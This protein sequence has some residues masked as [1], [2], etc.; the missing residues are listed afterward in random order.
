MFPLKDGFIRVAAGTPHIR[1]SDCEH[2]ADQ[3]IRLMKEARAAKAKIL[4][5][6]ELCLTG[7]TAGDLFAL[8]TLQNAAL[9]ALERVVKA[10]R[11][12]DLLCAVGLP[13]AVN[14][15][16]YDCAA[17]LQSGS[18]LAIVPKRRLPTH[19]PFE[20]TR[21]FAPGSA[22][23]R[24]IMLFDTQVPFGGNILLNCP[25]MPGLCVGVEISADLWAPAPPSIDHAK[26]GAVIILCP[27]AT[28]ETVGRAAYRK[29]LLASHSARLLCGYVYADAGN[30][31][32]T[33]DLVFAGHNLIAE[34][35][36]ILAASKRFECALVTA[37]LDVSYLVSDRLRLNCFG[38]QTGSHTIVPFHL[39]PEHLNLDRFIEPTPF[40]PFDEKTRA[41]RCEEILDIQTHGLMT[42]MLHINCTTAVIGV[43]G[44]LDSTL[45]LLVAARAFERM[46]LDAKGILAVTMPCFGTTRRT[47]DNALKLTGCVG[48]KLVEIDITDS[49]RQHF[50]DIGQDENSHDTTY[51]NCQARERTQVLMDLANQCGGLVIGTGDMSELALGWTTYNGDHMS[52]YAVNSGVPKTMV[53][54]LIAYTAEQ[55]REEGMREVLLDILKTPVSPELLPAKDGTISQVTEELVGPYELHDFFLYH[56]VR[57]MEEP[58]KI[59][60]L[61]CIAFEGTYPEQTIEKWLEVFLKRFFSQQYKR[62]C[63]PD[64]PRIGSVS[65]SPRGGWA[66]PSDVSGKAWH[67]VFSE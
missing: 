1:V 11:G 40:V 65:L 47:Y 43:S 39:K 42:R 18:I 6:P 27:A 14:G 62:S 54:H 63:L 34:N 67:R 56:L 46:G 35:G 15:R 41:R 20:E 23:V 26:E 13:L 55:A 28:V 12:M 21:Y 4:V 2:N 36:T 52:M 60:R 59:L 50:K 38:E 16:L 8:K 7:Y 61:A 17:I 31:E 25:E 57:R 49:V 22:Q 30:G 66:M 19:G 48:A 5:L 9:T 33:T 3:V 58:G 51:E 37:D 45:A 32:S 64:G 10:S 44:G 53:R 24:N 29:Q